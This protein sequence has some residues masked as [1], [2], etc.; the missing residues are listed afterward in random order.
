MTIPLITLNKN[1]GPF[2]LALLSPKT[3][4][5]QSSELWERTWNVAMPTI[6][7]WWVFAIHEV[8]VF[9]PALFLPPPSTLTQERVESQCKDVKEQTF[10]RSMTSVQCRKK[11]TTESKVKDFSQQVLLFQDFYIFIRSFWLACEKRRFCILPNPPKIK[12]F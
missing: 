11:K 2:T 8:H 5:S 6:Q 10:H 4:V 7:A 12:F 1:T 9:V 3:A